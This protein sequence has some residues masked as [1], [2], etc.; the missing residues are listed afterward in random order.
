M[1]NNDWVIP[2]DSVC[3]ITFIYGINFRNHTLQ[4]DERKQSNKF[5]VIIPD[6]G[7]FR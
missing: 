1:K 6:D 2:P 4:V 7:K 3:L 5:A